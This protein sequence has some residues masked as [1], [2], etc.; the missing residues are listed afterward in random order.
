METYG[1]NFDQQDGVAKRL[2]SVGWGLL[3][4]CVMTLLAQCVPQD[5]QHRICHAA[6]HTLQTTPR[7][8]IK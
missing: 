2:W 4:V 6:A 7:H 5:V 3:F 8:F 1:Q